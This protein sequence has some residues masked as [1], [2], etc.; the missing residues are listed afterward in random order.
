VKYSA[1]TIKG[2]GIG[3]RAEH[4]KTIL[5]EKP[6]V[7]WFEAVTENYMGARALPERHL[8]LIR[9]DYPIVFHGVSL[10]IGSSDPL[11][12]KYIAQLKA[13]QQ[14]FEPSWISDH[15]CWTSF[16]QNYIPDLLPL[17]FNESAISHLVDRI[18]LVQDLLGQ[19]I[20]LENISSY[21]RFKQ[22][23]MTE[24]EFMTEVVQRADCYILLDINNIYVNAQNHGF[25]ATHYLEGIPVE[26]VKQFHLAGYEDQ[27]TH[28]LDT[29]SRAVSEPVWNLYQKALV[30]FG[31]VPA[32]IE[33]DSDIPEFSTL[34][35]QAH[36]AES[37][38]QAEH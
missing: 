3:L 20:L 17:P 18:R 30:R 14:K 19:K 38:Q 32:L 6:K 36:Q 8:S 24:W 10:S 1:Q 26:R 35:A 22:A 15:L 16:N 29:H 28:L 11:N 33:W 13:L 21:L 9:R 23:D 5:E 7:P 4:Y 27:Q 37:Y 2:V 25:D 12:F 34:L 31:A